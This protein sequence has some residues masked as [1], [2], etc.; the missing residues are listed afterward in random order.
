MKEIRI[1]GV[2]GQAEGEI[3]AAWVR[4]QLPANGTDAIR[5]SFHSEGGSVF[6][7][8]TIADIF[9]AYTGHKVAAIES[10][11]FSISSYIP[12]TFD[13][14][15]VAPNAYFMLHNPRMKLEGDDEDLAKSAGMIADLKSN[16]VSAYAARTGKTPEQIQAV[17]KEETYFNATDAIAF[18][19]ADR[20][21]QTPVRGRA[22]AR[23]D[24]MPF[25]VVSALF[26]AGLG[27]DKGSQKGSKMSESTPVAATV[28]EIK[29]AFTVLA[30]AR[31]DFVLD[32][33]E[34]A[35]PM[36]S[37][38]AAA[39]EEM[40]KESEALRAENE[41][42]KARISAM[43]SEQTTPAEEEEPPAEAVAKAVEDEEKKEEAKARARGVRPVA[44]GTSG[45][46]SASARWHEAVNAATSEC[47]GD[48]MK[49]TA[50]ASRRNPGLREAFLAE[51][52]TR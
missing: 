23:M 44:K 27:G 11:A 30:K 6:E 17:L 51:A 48:K 47:R 24:E 28:K 15:E 3:S 10:T 35:L 26:G 5:V 43:E 32:C 18:G 13:E 25:G 1:D 7:G 38:A 34:R 36:A 14:I 2:I 52:N 49:A 9:R 12:M 4:E 41:E 40:M 16:M 45:R 42:L 29:S 19:L 33:I 22:F 31:P 20:V 8:F 39:A 46:P 50:L 21:T 37:V